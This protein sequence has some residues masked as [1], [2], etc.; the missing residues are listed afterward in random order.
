MFLHNA[1]VF[2]NLSVFFSLSVFFFCL[3]IDEPGS[4]HHLKRTFGQIDFSFY[5]SRPTT[6]RLLVTS[7]EQGLYAQSLW[8]YSE[9]DIASLLAIAGTMKG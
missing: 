1:W 9:A 2:H 7:P 4:L 5:A 8:S 3:S 6:S